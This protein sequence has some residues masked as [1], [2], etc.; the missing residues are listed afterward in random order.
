MYVQRWW[1][2]PFIFNFSF[3][4]F[5]L[6]FLSMISLY[7]VDQVNADWAQGFQERETSNSSGDQG[8][9]TA[10]SLSRCEQP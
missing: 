6:L 4:D 10:I 9:E 8:T 2:A 5:F 1:V 7:D 3:Y